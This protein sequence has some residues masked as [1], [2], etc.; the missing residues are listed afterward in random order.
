[1]NITKTKEY[2]EVLSPNDLCECDYCK[3]Y[4]KQIKESYPLLA[5]YLQNL[6]VDIE[7]PFETAPGGPEADGYIKY[8]FAQYIILG[9]SEGFCE[10]TIDSVEVSI[11]D[12]HPATDIEEEHFVVE[13]GLT[14]LKW[15]MDE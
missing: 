9:D 3:N 11:A 14:R 10:V 6:G 4:V 2:Y 1:M 12:S 7:K 5:E 13:I 8:F 15:V